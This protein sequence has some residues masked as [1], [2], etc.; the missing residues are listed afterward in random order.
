MDLRSKEKA[1]MPRS[2]RGLTIDDYLAFTDTRPRAERWELIEGEPKLNASPT[3]WHQ[4]IA[5]NIIIVLTREME[6]LE[7][8]WVPVIGIGTRVPASPR[9]LPEPDIM[10]L[11]HGLGPSARR[12]T[13]DALAVFEVISPSNKSGPETWRR[14]AF[15]SVP[16]L[17]HYVTLSQRRPEVVLYDRKASFRPKTLRSPR[18]ILRLDALGDVAIPIGEFFKHTPLAP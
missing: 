3:D 16:N 17:Q 15:A 7:A 8:R 18:S 1:D 2:A 9:S 12:E 5:A 6:R 4:R 13:S 10:V 14:N 11:E